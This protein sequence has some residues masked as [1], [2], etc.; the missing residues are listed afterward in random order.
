MKIFEVNG[1]RLVGLDV[2]SLSFFQKGPKKQK[3]FC[4]H[5]KRNKLAVIA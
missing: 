2:P 3:T 4:R 5:T 1:N